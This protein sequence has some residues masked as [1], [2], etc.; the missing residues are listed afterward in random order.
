MVHLLT[1][2]NLLGQKK[3]VDVTLNFDYGLH[4]EYLYI[5][6][7]GRAAYKVYA[8]CPSLPLNFT[9]GI[10][11]ETLPLKVYLPIKIDNVVNCQLRLPIGS[12]HRPWKFFDIIYFLL[13][14]RNREKTI[15]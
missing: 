12:R 13:L 7:E 3:A 11:L 1:N 8:G 5:D 4:R 15:H 14:L 6:I 2:I 10:L 9:L